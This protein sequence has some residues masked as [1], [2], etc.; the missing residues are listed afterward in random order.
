MDLDEPTAG[1]DPLARHEL[2]RIL[3]E[4][5]DDHRAIVFS[6]HHGE[7]VSALADEV[8]FLYGGRVI[9][10][11]DV[12]SFLRGGRTLEAAFLEQVSQ[13]SGGRAA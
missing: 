11:A 3:A 10:R 13:L 12:A 2:I 8:A 9:A 7:D 6:S 1:L 5:R 4:S